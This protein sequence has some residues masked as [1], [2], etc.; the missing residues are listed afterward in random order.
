KDAA[1]NRYAP[2]GWMGDTADLTM[3]DSITEPHSGETSLKFTYTPKAG[4]E[5][6]V[7]VYWMNKEN[8]WGNE[9]GLDLSGATKLTFWAKGEK[10]GE[11]IDNISVGGVT[12]QYPDTAKVETGPIVLS[13]EWKKYEIDLTG[14]DLSSIIGGFCFSTSAQSA[15]DGIT[16]Y[17]DDIQFEK[18]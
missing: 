5:G 10:G 18:I 15:G 8:N 1:T 11:T 4:R 7:G 12:G 14:K 6:W 13:N 17:I 16:F 9:E 3:T 2:T